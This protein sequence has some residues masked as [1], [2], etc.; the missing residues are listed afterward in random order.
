MVI[1]AE[2][3]RL[4][5]LPSDLVQPWDSLLVAVLGPCDFTTIFETNLSQT[6][7]PCEFLMGTFKILFEMNFRRRLCQGR[8]T[9]LSQNLATASQ[10]DISE[11]SPAPLHPLSLPRQSPW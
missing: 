7:V 9:L 2:N 11:V 1:S 6:L 4:N 10:C 8:F 5:V 3:Y